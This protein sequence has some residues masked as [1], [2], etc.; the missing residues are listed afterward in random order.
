MKMKRTTS[1]VIAVG[2]MTMFGLTIA[3]APISAD[4]TGDFDITV[5]AGVVSMTMNQSAWALGTGFSFNSSV[6]TNATYD[7]WLQVNNTGN[8]IQDFQVSVDDAAAT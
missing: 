8:I 6:W 7:S 1:I 3:P 5:T 2:L 4:L